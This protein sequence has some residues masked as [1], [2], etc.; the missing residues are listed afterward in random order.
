MCSKKSG[1]SQKALAKR[2][3][4]VLMTVMGRQRDAPLRSTVPYTNLLAVRV[5]REAE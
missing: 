1:T 4:R 5:K 2:E 3:R